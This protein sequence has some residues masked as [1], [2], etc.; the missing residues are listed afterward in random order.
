M[1]TVPSKSEDPNARDFL[2]LHMRDLPYFR[3]LLRAVESRFYQQ[4]PLPAPVYDVG[5]GDGHFAS[6]TFESKIDAGL[7]PGHAP[8]HEAR[9]RG[10]YRT[11][12]EADGARAPF[13]D[14]YFASAF[15]NS[16]LEHIPH[17]E[18]VLA[19]TARVL[20]PGAPFL[21]CVPNQNFPRALSVARFLD[22]TGLVG[23]ADAYRRFFNRISRHLHCDD[24]E[25]WAKRLQAA[26][27]AVESYWS[28]FSPSALAALE[29]GHLLGLPSLV[30]K[31][32]F[33]RWTLAPWRVNLWLTMAP[34]RRYYNEPVPQER[35]AYTFY[36]TR[37]THQ[38]VKPRPRDDE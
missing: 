16:V 6:I 18:A 11:L 33:G 2:F 14:N 32:L 38:S 1:P 37:R 19:E 26:G 25:T 30:S 31:K 12:V 3:A 7:D 29:W 13:P 9:S 36:V 28:Y 17:V 34:L 35:G 10:A 27:F 8:I 21:F 5:C 22:R 23:A 4:R 20:A 24:P 15:S